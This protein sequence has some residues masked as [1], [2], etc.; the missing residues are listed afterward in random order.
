MRKLFIFLPIVCLLLTC[1]E[2]YS[3]AVRNESSHTVKFTLTTGYRTQTG[4]ELEPDES[5]I[6]EPMPTSLRHSLDAFEPVEDVNVVET[7]DVYTFF[8]NPTLE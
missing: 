3:P 7:G 6:H 4:L 2:T 5:Y 8:D 1:T